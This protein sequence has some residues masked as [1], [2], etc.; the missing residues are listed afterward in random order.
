LIAEFSEDAEI[1]SDS[2]FQHQE[3]VWGWRAG[4]GAVLGEK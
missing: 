3:W 4:V 1:F 2:G